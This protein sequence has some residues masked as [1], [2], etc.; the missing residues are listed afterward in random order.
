MSLVNQN[1]KTIMKV[2][3][4]AEEISYRS[5]SPITAEHMTKANQVQQEIL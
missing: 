2:D 1:N 3:S 5:E 4:R